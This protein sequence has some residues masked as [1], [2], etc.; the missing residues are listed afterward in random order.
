MIAH[1]KAIYLSCLALSFF[2]SG[3]VLAQVNR[4]KVQQQADIEIGKLYHNLNTQTK[5]DIPKR[6]EYFS[7][8][9]LGRPYELGPLGEGINNRFDQYPL[10]RTDSFD[11]ETYV[12]TVLAL[13]L[14]ND[15][16]LFKQYIQH[17]RYFEG[18]IEYTNRVHFT[19]V[20]WNGNNQQQGFL[21]DITHTI[22][23]EESK[24]VAEIA[25]AW[26]D[27]PRWFSQLP[28]SSIRLLNATPEL[29]QQ[30]LAILHQ[31]GQKVSPEKSLL[32]YLPLKHLFNAQKEPNLYIFKQIPHTAIIEIVRPD[33]DLSKEIG[34]HLNV[35]HLGFA[36]WKDNV[37]YFRQASSQEQNH[38]QVVDVPLIEYLKNT[39]ESPTIKGINIQVIIPHKP[40]TLP[41]DKLTTNNK[42]Q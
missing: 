9:F 39:L 42:S 11:C 40:Y 31:E 15:L 10:Y 41:P 14:A 4:I 16:E 6:M 23:N 24:P 5:Y 21:K 25:Q 3:T 27:K 29:Q 12:T 8:H 19:E 18:K 17:I 2:H 20:D 28:L 35:S 13:T 37:L 32:A 34:T 26:I 38:R 22:L 33:W 30:R 7:Q 36:V 1:L